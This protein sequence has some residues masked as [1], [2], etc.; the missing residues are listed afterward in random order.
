MFPAASPDRTI[1]VTE[2]PVTATDTVAAAVV[3]LIYAVVQIVLTLGHDP[4]LDEAQ[5]WLLASGASSPLD[6]LI[7][8][9]EGH[10][11]L[12]YWLLW[13]V[14]RFLDFSQARFITLPV[15][16]LNAFLLSRVLRGQVPILLLVLA[17]F[18]VLQFWGYHFRPYGLVFTCLLAAL[19]LERQGRSVAATWAMTIGCGLHFMAGFLFAFWLFWQW[20]KGT[21]IR[22]LVA[23]S[24]FSLAF[25]ICAVLSCTGNTAT[26]TAE[27]AAGLV[28]S[29][30]GNLGWAGMVEPLRGPVVALLTVGGIAWCLRQCPRVAVVLI[31][32][33][34][35]FAISTALVYGRSPWHSAFLTMLCLMAFSLVG[36]NRQRA[37]FMAIL[38]LPQVAFGAA[39]VQQRL[40]HPAWNEDDLYRLVSTD[41]GP[42]FAPE[43]DLVGWPSLAIPPYTAIYG[44]RMISGN[45]GT[46]IGPID[47]ST[48]HPERI[49]ARL[50]DKPGPY[51]LICAACE[52]PL[53]Y[54]KDHGR[55]ATLLGSKFMV[56]Q[57]STFEA[58]RIER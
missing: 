49:D 24:L 7:L 25:G 38:M 31:A 26:G 51:W 3:V 9:G 50:A 21:A 17:S 2:R 58:Y 22:R 56:D 47:W 28:L 52:L 39:A 13:G 46:V 33:L 6:L 53:G 42:G 29:A 1:P 37:W 12:W 5:A 34:V 20:Q 27:D 41:A 44:A 45:D 23:P 16:V 35:I 8:P 43:T 19:L 40:Q 54:L 30:L 48:F 36:F 55:S 15:A 4:W 14:S 32:L 18:P 57:A 10:P 11:P